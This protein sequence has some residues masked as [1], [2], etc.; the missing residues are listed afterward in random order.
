MLPDHTLNTAFFI[1]E[2][3]SSI[4]CELTID[5]GEQKGQVIDYYIEH[6]PDDADFKELMKHITM[7]QIHSNTFNYIR[8]T[9]QEIKRVA[10]EVAKNNGWILSDVSL[11]DDIGFKRQNENPED[12]SSTETIEGIKEV[13]VIPKIEEILTSYIFNPE[14]DNEFIFEL[15]LKLFEMDFIKSNS[16]RE[17]KKNLRVAKTVG[18]AIIAAI[19]IWE[20]RED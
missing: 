10:I 14:L 2:D 3:R 4:Q 15:K 9:Q 16:N 7:D 11:K 17:L 8:T 18:Q 5:K 13:K 6:N 12:T 20:S 19:N 1:N